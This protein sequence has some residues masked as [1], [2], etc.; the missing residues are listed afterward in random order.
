MTE[1][2]V[3]QALQQGIAAH[4]EGKLQEA[5][6]LYRIILEI[7]PQHPDANHNLGVIAVAVGKINLAL[8][9]FKKALETSSEVEQFWF[10][11]IEALIKDRVMIGANFYAL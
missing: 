9:L 7:Q 4:R 2:T 6:R 8:P 5:E 3:G 10:S 11:Y 1:L